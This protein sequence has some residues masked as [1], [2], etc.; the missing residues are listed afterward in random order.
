M[1]DAQKIEQEEAVCAKVADQVSQAWV[2]LIDDA[3]LQKVVEELHT[4][5]TKV[6]QLKYDMKQLPLAQ[7]MAKETEM[8]KLQQQVTMLCIQ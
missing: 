2:S 6:N 7:K 4:D 8:R 1:E 5:D 3:K